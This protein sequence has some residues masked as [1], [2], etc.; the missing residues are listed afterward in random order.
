MQTTEKTFFLLNLRDTVKL[1]PTPLTATPYFVWERSQLRLAMP[2]FATEIQANEGTDGLNLTVPIC[3]FK[4][5][6]NLNL[7]INMVLRFQ[8]R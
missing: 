5:F 2:S 4:T 1:S 3:G 7:L 8:Y 6:I